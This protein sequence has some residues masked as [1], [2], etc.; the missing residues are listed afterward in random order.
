MHIL[1]CICMFSS[2]IENCYKRTRIRYQ[3]APNLHLYHAFFF[4]FLKKTWNRN[5]LVRVW[6]LPLHP[7]LR[8]LWCVLN[9]LDSFYD[10]RMYPTTVAANKFCKPVWPSCFLSCCVC[11]FLW[12]S[13]VTAFSEY[14]KYFDKHVT[15]QIQVPFHHRVDTF[16]TS[17][18]YQN[19]RTIFL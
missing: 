14:R 5:N 10:N 13:H 9:E 2:I 4:F 1:N 18:I 6:V 11:S 17:S 16:N 7:P 15:K 8:T 12:K 19:C 3:T